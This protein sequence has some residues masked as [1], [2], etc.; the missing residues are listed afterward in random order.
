MKQVKHIVI[1]KKE[2]LTNMILKRAITRKY[3]KYIGEYKVGGK[4]FSGKLDLDI[5]T[6]HQNKDDIHYIDNF[7]KEEI[8][9][10]II[11]EINGN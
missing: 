10:Q 9:K 6:Y 5:S 1:K 8:A 3:L 4:L 7:A 2:L 11:N